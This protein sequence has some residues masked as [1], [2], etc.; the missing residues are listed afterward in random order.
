VVSR[1]GEPIAI[2]RKLFYAFKVLQLSVFAGWCAMHAG[3]SLVPATGDMAALGI[4]GRVDRRRAGAQLE[5]LL[6]I[7]RGRS[8]LRRSL[9]I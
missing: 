8:I 3:E 4:G 2:V 9:G 6:S 1:F 5:R 7:G